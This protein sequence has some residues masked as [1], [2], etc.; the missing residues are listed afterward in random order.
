MSAS[1]DT[2]RYLT[3]F[4][5]ARIG[6]VVT[7]V[8]VIGSGVAGARAAIEAAKHGFVTLISKGAFDDSS[9]RYAQGGIAAVMASDD[10]TESHFDDTM[11]VGCGLNRAEAVRLLVDDGPARIDE[12]ISWGL[13]F[14]RVD[15]ELA[16]GLE[17]GHG[18]PR[19]VHADGDQIGR[20]LSTT[21]MR[22]VQDTSA[23]RVFEHCFL[24]D[25]V[26]IDGACVGAVAYHARHGHQLIWA[27]RTILASGGCGQ[28]WRE[29]TNP[30]VATG[31]GP[32]TA[33]RAGASLSDMEMMQFHPTTLYVA[34]SGRA[35]ISEAVRGEGAYLVDQTG[36]RFMTAFHPDGELAPRDVV[37]RAIHRRLREIRSNC[38]YLDVRHLSGFAERFPHI[39]KLCADFQIDVT[40]DPIPVRPSAHYMIGGV[41]VDLDGRSSLSGLFACGEAAATGVHGAN[42][43]ASNSLLEGLVF[44]RISGDLAGAEAAEARNGARI[45]H[46]SNVGPRSERTS[47]DLADIRNSL[48]SLMWR[49]AGIIRDGQRLRETCDI[50]AFW[51]HYTMDKTFDDVAG[52]ETQNQLT[53]ARL[54]AMS[55]LE[56]TES[57]GVHFRGDDPASA[58][59]SSPGT[60]GVSEPASA[61]TVATEPYHVTITRTETGTQPLRVPHV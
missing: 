2:R 36:E 49:N 46:A 31:D 12:L 61:D 50:L 3:D 9:T 20:A 32:A 6:H 24:I 26:T 39:T 5:S 34:G 57:V 40:R 10:S 25:L 11:R 21:L 30:S 56:R 15:G 7:D 13:P 54:V 43:L 41:T 58:P 59:Q 23:I 42:R 35:L 4:D 29:T 1:Y 33:F 22:R 16:P 47:L 51:G 27:G 19:V 52:W 8:L 45:G 55:A 14:D 28:V 18:M 60:S 17:G 38:V 44:G 48:H 37:S 53:V